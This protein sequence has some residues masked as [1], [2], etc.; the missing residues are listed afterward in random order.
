MQAYCLFSIAISRDNDFGIENCLNE[1]P[2]PD[3]SLSPM[4]TGKSSYEVT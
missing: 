4:P 2:F 1:F 3:G